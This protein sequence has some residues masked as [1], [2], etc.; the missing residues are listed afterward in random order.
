[1]RLFR[2]RARLRVLVHRVTPTAPALER[3]LEALA[4]DAPPVSAA[5]VLDT[6]EGG[7]ALP[8]GAVLHAFH[9][10]ATFGAELWPV[11]RRHGVAPVLFLARSPDEGSSERRAELARLARAGVALGLTRPSASAAAPS[12]GCAELRQA[13]RTI[14]QLSPV[15]P[16]LLAHAAGRPNAA[17]LALAR[18]AGVELAVSTLTGAN[19]LERDDPLCLRSIGLEPELPHAELA[20][21]LTATGEPLTVEERDAARA[22][23]TA[24][25]RLRRR[26]LL[27]AALSARA[28]ASPGT[29]RS[30]YERV[31]RG[32]GRVLGHWPA[33]ARR[34][35]AAL[36]DGSR[37]PFRVRTLELAGQGSA[38]SV[39]HLGSA[40]DATHVLKLYRWTLGLPAPLLLQMAR[41]HHAR[42]A[43]LREWL[44][45]HLLETQVLV[46]HGPLRGWPVA[47]CLQERVR[48]S[49]DLLGLPEDEL[50]ARLAADP[51]LA[52]EGAELAERV[53]RAHTQGFLPDLLGPGN[54]LWIP[55]GVRPRL[56]LLDYGLFDL[57]HG[58]GAL[59]AAALAGAL[60]R[61]ELLRRPGLGAARR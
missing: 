22:R 7:H 6:L 31:R 59:S 24:R 61:V 14:A 9:E 55:A 13:L 18:A 34:V 58:T 56:R 43:A 57:R 8:A 4:P 19:D 35:E 2:G 60:R 36:L 3:V 48:Q 53:R 54:L 1:V 17:A 50:A 32:F 10:G 26:L 27:D 29:P 33:L 52:A 25:S 47:A 51:E 45:P 41:R 12:A 15:A 16:R 39:F 40:P 23:A 21:R 44:G 5:C 28:P 11:L 38:A 46:L 37:L 20:P 49:V 42:L 30:S